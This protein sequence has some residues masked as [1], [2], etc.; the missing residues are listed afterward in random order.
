MHILQYLFEKIKMFFIERVVE[1][2][3]KKGLYSVIFV[4]YIC[5]SLKSSPLRS[6]SEPWLR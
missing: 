3:Y 2:L 4:V 1:S 6:K 5:M